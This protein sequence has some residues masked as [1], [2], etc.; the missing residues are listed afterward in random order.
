M[1][2]QHKTKHHIA[3]N[4]CIF[5][6]KIAKR[7]ETPKYLFEE[8]VCYMKVLFF[9]RKILKRTAIAIGCVVLMFIVLKLCEVF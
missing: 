6:T 3:Y 7:K 9:K 2:K 5:Y 4:F 8:E 1:C